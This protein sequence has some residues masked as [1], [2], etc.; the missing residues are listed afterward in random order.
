WLMISLMSVLPDTWM[1]F[2]EMTWM[3]L[4]LTSFGAAMREPVTMISCSGG[5]SCV[6]GGACCA[7]PGTARASKNLSE[8]GVLACCARESA[9]LAPPEGGGGDAA[10]PS[11]G[12][13]TLSGT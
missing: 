4:V 5:E 9:A 6:T 11:A 7:E 1:D 10:G 13:G 12:A 8:A 2:A 3:G